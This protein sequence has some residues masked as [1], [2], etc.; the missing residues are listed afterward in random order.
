MELLN[1][2]SIKERY[3]THDWQYRAYESFESKMS[4]KE[5]RFPCIPATQGF[6]LDQF[7]YGFCNRFETTPTA[8]Q[9][10]TLLQA[11]TARYETLG[12]YTSL[13][14]FIDDQQQNL[15]VLDYEKLFWSLLQE[16]VKI[17]KHTWPAHIPIDPLDH[18]WEF[19]FNGVGYFVFCATPAHKNRQ[20]RHFPHLMLA[21]TPRII[22]EKFH[23]HSPAALIKEKIRKRLCNYDLIS[24]HPELK[25]Y[26]QTDNLEAKQ[27]F[28]R[29]DQTSFSGCPF[30]DSFKKS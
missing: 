3:T 29:D 25:W 6:A 4:D 26:G 17:N 18:T 20:S 7:L 2:K 11:Y 15:N 19:H 21:I 13:I 27:Y 14:I 16:V 23:D 1:R 28:L 10:V 12:D 5:K 22:L 30:A 9:L 8:K 24:P